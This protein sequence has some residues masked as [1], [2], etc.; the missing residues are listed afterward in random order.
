[1]RQRRE[2]RE[3]VLG[4]GVCLR[5]CGCTLGCQGA[6]VAVACTAGG[7]EC[8]GVC[9]SDARAA[10]LA[11]VERS[12]CMTAVMAVGVAVLGVSSCSWRRRS[13]RSRCARAR[14]NS[15]WGGWRGPAPGVLELVELVALAA[16]VL[17]LSVRPS[18]AM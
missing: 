11:A 5:L 7:L 15:S 2:C 14:R 17:L 1:M 3:Q 16:A 8:G 18:G 4:Q 10:A 12:I 13:H 6:Q 9:P